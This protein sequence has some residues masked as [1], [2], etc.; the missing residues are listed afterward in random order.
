MSFSSLLLIVSLVLV[1]IMMAA[2][3]EPSLILCATPYTVPAS[4]RPPSAAPPSGL[5]L[6]IFPK[7]GRCLYVCSPH[8]LAAH[9]YL[10]LT[11]LILLSTEIHMRLTLFMAD[12]SPCKHCWQSYRSI[13]SKQEAGKAVISCCHEFASFSSSKILHI[14]FICIALSHTITYI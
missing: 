6:P 11:A 12:S 2:M 4:S 14:V 1:Q 3:F 7:G 10:F 9:P 5:A 8:N 13:P